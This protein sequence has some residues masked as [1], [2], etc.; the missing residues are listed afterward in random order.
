[1]KPL[2]RCLRGFLQDTYLVISSLGYLGMKDHLTIGRRNT[3]QDLVPEEPMN[4][5]SQ[6]EY[7][8]QVAPSAPPQQVFIKKAI[9]PAKRWDLQQIYLYRLYNI[10]QLENLPKTWRILASLQKD[11]ARV[12]LK[13]AFQHKAR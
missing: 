7:I 12:A 10:K 8:I 9:T 5:Q 2:L 6:K 11:K 4:P 3:L 1:M 13:I